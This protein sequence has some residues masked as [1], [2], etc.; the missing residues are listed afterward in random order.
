MR[1][2]LAIS[3]PILL[4]LFLLVPAE[5]SGE[6]LDLSGINDKINSIVHYAEEYEVGNIN[7]LQLNVYGHKI[8][9]DLNLMLGGSI[10]EEW[11]RIPKENIENTFGQP[12]EYTDWIW[13]DNKHL[14]IRLECNRGRERRVIQIL[15]C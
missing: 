1:K 8:R 15:F 14:H 12:T 3:F 4:A 5:V 9:A 11:A 6:D 13:I 7:Y 2:V 10:G